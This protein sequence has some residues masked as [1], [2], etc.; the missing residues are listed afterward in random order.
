MHGGHGDPHPN[1]GLEPVAALGQRQARLLAEVLP[2]RLQVLLAEERLAA[3][4]L[5]GREVT[6]LALLLDVALHAA[7]ADPEQFGD[8]VDVLAGSDAVH[9]AR[10]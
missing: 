7:G 10:A 8:L 5:L 1:L 9:D 2:Q 3:R 4:V 6:M